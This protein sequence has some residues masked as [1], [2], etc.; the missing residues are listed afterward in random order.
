MV[1][2]LNKRKIKIGVYNLIL[3]L[4]N[5]HEKQYFKSIKNDDYIISKSLINKD[6]KVL[7]LGANI[8]LT[9]LIYLSF[10]ASE[11]YA[12]EPV[13]ELVKRLKSIKTNCIKVFD[14]ALSDYNG[15]SEIYLSTSHNQGNSLN[16]DWPVLFSNVFKKAKKEEVKVATLDSLL[17]A[18][19][20]N[21]IKIDVEGM[22]EKTVIGGDTFFKRNSEAIVQIEIYDWQ[23]ERTHDLLSK[24][25]KN[26]YVPVIEK[27]TLKK[28]KS[29]ASYKKGE[30]IQFSGPPN[31]IYSNSLI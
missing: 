29:L 12:F 23:F 31:Y 22:E 19:V 11:V 28:F 27:G 26:T 13:A 9:A 7:D 16:D 21:F 25:Y 24:Y 10:G 20:F 30:E 14:Y 1:N 17:T 15:F 5:P 18:E 8:G 6:D 4:S 2:F 3:D